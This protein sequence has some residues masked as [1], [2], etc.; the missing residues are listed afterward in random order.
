MQVY[1]AVHIKTSQQ[2]KAGKKKELPFQEYSVRSGSKEWEE[3]T[4]MHSLV[5]QKRKTK[6]KQNK[7]TKKFIFYLSQVLY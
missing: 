6:Q 5:P 4:G 1:L 2:T 3:V 7:L